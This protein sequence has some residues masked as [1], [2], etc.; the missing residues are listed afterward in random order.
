MGASSAATAARSRNVLRM[1]RANER[2][3]NATIS[4]DALRHKRTSNHSH[5]L[6]ATVPLRCCCPIGLQ[7]LRVNS[8]CVAVPSRLDKFRVHYLTKE[9]GRI[10][11]GSALGDDAVMWV[12]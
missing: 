7:C 6:L 10:N 5:Q 2:A 1:F 3:W 8:Q 12:G 11:L 9:D 4:S